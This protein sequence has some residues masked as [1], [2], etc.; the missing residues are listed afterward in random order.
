M[1]DVS[2]WA[3]VSPDD[4]LAMKPELQLVSRNIVAGEQGRD[5]Q[6]WQRVET[7]QDSAGNPVQTTNLAYMEMQ[8][9]MYYLEGKDWKRASC[10]L[11]RSSTGQLCTH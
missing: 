1:L 2:A 6:T 3:Q 9:G 4:P 8:T 5:F 11:C 7:F 10:D